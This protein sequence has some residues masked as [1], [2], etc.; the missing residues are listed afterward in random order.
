M[1]KDLMKILKSFLLN[2]VN[3]EKI[4]LELDALRDEFPA[5]TPYEL[6]EILIKRSAMTSSL[7]GVA[8][9][10][11]PWPFTLLFAFPDL[12]AMLI[13]QS[14]MIYKISLLADKQSD[15]DMRVTE[16]V[17]CLGASLGAGAVTIGMRKI[18]D[19]GIT[20]PLLKS[21]V[22][23]MLTTY[24]KKSV[25]RI[26]PFVGGVVGGSI[27]FLSTVAIGNIAKDYYFPIKSDL[28]GASEIGT[29]SPDSFYDEDDEDDYEDEKPAES[30]DKD[31][32]DDDDDDDDKY[33]DYD[34]A[35][36][37]V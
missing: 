34:G 29:I 14:K 23:A 8:T 13:V 4:L 10:S 16:I 7:S 12:I 17:A 3:E 24:L 30:I 18:L 31:D 9:G 19:T 21:I 1:D 37:I 25:S 26:P 5:H 36:E 28:S 20:L 27:N 33:E 6:T 35:S 32:D 2:G 22:T 15:E 11:I